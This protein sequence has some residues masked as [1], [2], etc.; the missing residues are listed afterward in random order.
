MKE[1]IYM[2]CRDLKK[3]YTMYKTIFSENIY[4]L[5]QILVL[6]LNLAM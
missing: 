2:I 5:I 4:T 1:G 3:C 6:L